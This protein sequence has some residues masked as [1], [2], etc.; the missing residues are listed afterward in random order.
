MLVILRLASTSNVGLLSVRR[1]MK[2]VLEK[3][4]QLI[5]HSFNS[6][7]VDSIPPL[8]HY[9]WCKAMSSEV[10]HF[11]TIPTFQVKFKF[12]ST[13]LVLHG[14]LRFNLLFD[15]GISWSRAYLLRCCF[16][17]LSIT[18]RVKDSFVQQMASIWKVSSLIVIV[19]FSS[20][21]PYPSYKFNI[22]EFCKVRTQFLSRM[23]AWRMCIEK[24]CLSLINSICTNESVIVKFFGWDI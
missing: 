22:Q 3:L 23:E 10:H 20:P 12:P 8:F 5:K 7:C 14:Y 17:W 15:V 24:F 1:L 19:L 18:A 16:P 4:K 11:Y 2:R 9:T 6:S 13:Y 21:F